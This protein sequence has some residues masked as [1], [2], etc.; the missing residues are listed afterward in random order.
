MFDI[1]KLYMLYGNMLIFS[2]II[3]SFLSVEDFPYSETR[4]MIA[5]I[6]DFIGTVIGLLS[7][8]FPKM[9]FSL[10]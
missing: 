5:Y 3:S 6:L 9:P 2:I 8:Y 1:Y 7:E 4:E 10:F